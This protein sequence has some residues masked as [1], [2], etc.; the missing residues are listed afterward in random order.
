MED[1]AFLLVMALLPVPTFAD[2]INEAT[3]FHQVGARLVR[4]I[5][6][7][8]LRM[9]VDTVGANSDGGTDIGLIQVNSS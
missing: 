9:H 6:Q 1:S 3:K 7:V 4:T 2:C 8:E 5:A